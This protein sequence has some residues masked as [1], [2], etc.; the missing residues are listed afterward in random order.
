MVIQTMHMRLL[1]KK[2]AET[3]MTNDGKLV[4]LNHP[5]QKGE[6][7]LMSASEFETLQGYFPESC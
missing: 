7:N 1:L 3:D 2:L 6:I 4:Q 5:F